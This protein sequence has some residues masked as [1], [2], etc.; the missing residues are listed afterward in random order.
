MSV[1]TGAREE[2]TS[3]REELNE[4]KVENI[5]LEFKKSV[6]M[7]PSEDKERRK[8]N[9][10]SRFDDFVVTDPKPS[11]KGRSNISIFAECLD[12]IEAEFER[13]FSSENVQLWQAM[14]ALSPNS[15]VFFSL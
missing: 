2:L 10:T 15:C 1:L 5:L 13:R 14:E 9:M 11:K 6:N 8:T 3:M 4:E 7:T 12:L